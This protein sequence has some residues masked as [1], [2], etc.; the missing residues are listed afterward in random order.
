MRQS[1]TP[2][3]PPPRPEVLGE[4]AYLSVQ[5]DGDGTVL[6]RPAEGGW[7]DVDATEFL[8]SVTRLA[9]GL[10][11]AGVGLG[12]RV[13]VAA[14]GGY[15]R[16][17]VVFAVWAAGGVVVEVPPNCSPGLLRRALRDSRPAVAVLR[18][19]RQTR[20][21]ASLQHELVDLG[22]VWTVDDAGLEAIAKPGAY[23]DGTAVRFRVEES[24]A[25]DTALIHYTVTPQR[26]VRGA[27]LTHRNLLAAAGAA[28]DR[29]APVLASM[30]AGAATTLLGPRTGGL[31]SC[32]AVVAGVLAGV[33]VG[34]AHPEQVFAHQVREFAPTLL[35]T[36]A[37]FLTRVYEVERSR[38]RQGGWD[39]AQGFEAA[40]RLA[41]DLGRKKRR[42]W[43]RMSRAIYDWAFARVR[44]ALGGQVRAAVCV[45][46]GLEPRLAYFYE[47]LGIPVLEGF[48][49]AQTGGVA[50]LTVPGQPRPGTVGP[51]VDGVELKTADDGEVLVRGPGVFAGYH[52]AVQEDTQVLPDG[53]LA[54]GR[55]GELDEQGYL[56]VRE[57]VPQVRSGRE[58][59]VPAVGVVTDGT[60][61]SATADY[62]DL[63]TQLLAHPLISQVIVL[64]EGRPYATAL[65]TLKR[66][67]LEYWRLI[68]NL[69]LSTPLE[70]IALAPEVGAEIR[71]V[72]EEVNN[73][74]PPELMIRAFHVLPEEFSQ[75]SGLLLPSGRLRRD[76]VLRAFADEIEA[77]YAPPSIEE[78]R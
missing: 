3:P 54:T 47:G 65:I 31:A 14:P 51:A 15:E 63:E 75:A 67:Q 73:G 35:V 10:I 77:L 46:G 12:D 64:G 27:V 22:R 69:P 42:P 21:A 43:Q 25:Q 2:V 78:G 41:V 36:D 8:T 9:R 45:P 19:Q 55:L 61:R 37:A 52:N 1:P 17:L 34:F 28:V 68:N 74:V 53:W 24:T 20:V 4:L 33:R 56:T 70:Q 58:A 57:A 40:T 49:L 50:A 23:M 48:G 5:R 26:R 44:D 38:A 30:P 29:L 6:H 60:A 13:L 32:S 72:V 71:R 66:D 59:E 76:A 18:D 39:G 11:A 62:V 16:T 7:R